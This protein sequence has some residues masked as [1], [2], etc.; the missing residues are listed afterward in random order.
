MTNKDLVFNFSP[1]EFAF[2]YEGCKKCY[3]DK[4]VNNIVLKTPFPGAFSKYL[5]CIIFFQFFVN[6]FNQIV[7]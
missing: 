1:S 6:F 5:S 2:D 3:Y 7:I 4:K